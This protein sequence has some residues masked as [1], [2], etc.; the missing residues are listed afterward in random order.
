MAVGRG[1]SVLD[2]RARA[3]I[4]SLPILCQWAD[5]SRALSDHTANGASKTERDNVR[6]FGFEQGPGIKGPRC[7]KLST[8]L[9][10]PGLVSP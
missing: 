7:P 4:L 6:L 8:K 3:V 10:F 9:F 2:D 1:E 5:R